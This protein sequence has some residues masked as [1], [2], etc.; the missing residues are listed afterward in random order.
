MIVAISGW[1]GSGKDLIANYLVKHYGAVRIA[2]ADPLKDGVASQYSIP[3]D[4]LDRI[5]QKESPIV[6]L[7]VKPQDKFSRMIAEFMFKEFRSINGEVPSDFGYDEAGFFGVCGR[8][9][10]PLYW[11]P[12]ALA[13]LEGSTKRSA[14]AN[15]WVKQAV[16]QVKPDGLY[17]ISDLR[18]TNEINALHTAAPNQVLVVRVDRFDVSPSSDP[19]E[20]DLDAFPFP[21]V[22]NNRSTTGSLFDQV[23]SL[24]RSKGFNVRHQA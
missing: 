22:L 17:V 1:K 13:I 21:Y 15:H 24:M 16:S 4:S 3:R 5:D 23:D 11:T 20:R 9:T 7:P 19:S 6:S 18:Y 14:D 10:F 12:R 2:F 8:D